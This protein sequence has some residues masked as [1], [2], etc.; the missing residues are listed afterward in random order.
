M[1]RLTAAACV[2][3]SALWVAPAAAS[4][5]A[6]GG[7]RALPLAGDAA[8]GGTRTEASTEPEAVAAAGVQMA[9]V[10]AP[11]APSG[12]TAQLQP[13]V[14]LVEDPGTG[15]DDE[16]GS[17]TGGDTGS[18]AGS[19][20]EPQGTDESAPAT[21]SPGALASTGFEPAL[22]AALGYALFL[23]GAVTRRTNARPG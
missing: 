1:A 4:Y 21:A 18:D 11:R 3:A 15:G 5:E 8:T 12:D 13:P 22:L 17:D 16:G 9:R 10:Q 6:T 7:M 2:V 19:T 23:L 20:A 14:P